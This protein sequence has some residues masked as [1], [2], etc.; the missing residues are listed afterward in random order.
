MT[1]RFLQ[2]LEYRRDRFPEQPIAG[3]FFANLGGFLMGL[4]LGF[5][6]ILVNEREPSGW[7]RRAVVLPAGWQAIEIERLWIHGREATL[8]A[9]QGA[10]SAMLSFR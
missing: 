10:T 1:D 4:I 6:G 9:R 3:P 7:P 8:S 2:T 5:P